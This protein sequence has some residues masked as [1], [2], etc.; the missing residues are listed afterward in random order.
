[1]DECEYAWAAGLFEGEGSIVIA[2][3]RQRYYARLIVYS[4]DRDVLEHWQRLL[5]GHIRA[6]SPQKDGYKP[7]FYVEL[8]AQDQVK[9]ALERMAPWLGERRTAR[10]AE[11]LA[12]VAENPPTQYGT[13][14]A[15][16]RELYGANGRH[17]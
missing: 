3:R 11:V 6:R 16:R 10:V 8:G 12:K 7:A 17:A 4:T 14:W 1:M 2:R 9:A 5:G 13:G 15:K